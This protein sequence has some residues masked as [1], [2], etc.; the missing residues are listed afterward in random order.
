MKKIFRLTESQLSGLIK[1][2]L[3]ESTANADIIRNYSVKQLNWAEKQDYL[4]N[5]GDINANLANIVNNIVCDIVETNPKCIGMFTAGN[6]K[7]HH[8][9][10]KYVSQHTLGNAVDFV[11][12]SYCHSTVE[13]ILRTYK[14]NVPGFTYINEY[15]NPT[16]KATGG[17]F[18]LELRA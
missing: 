6:D 4:S 5:G 8:S 1:K 17:H 10:K 13:S 16:K 2:L 15:K 12:P 18:H 9:I 14:Q 7:F 3:S 11:V